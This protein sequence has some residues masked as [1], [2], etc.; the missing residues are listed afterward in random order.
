MFSDISLESLE[1]CREAATRLG[2]INM[3]DFVHTGLPAL[4]AIPDQ[5]VDVV[6]LSSVLV[7]VADKK[8]ALANLYRVLRQG[9]R[10]ALF[11][12]INCF[13]FPRLRPLPMGI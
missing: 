11:Q 7:Y 13:N 12:S 4:Q 9:G 1:A 5:S 10:L 8:I 2:I 6:T 3:C